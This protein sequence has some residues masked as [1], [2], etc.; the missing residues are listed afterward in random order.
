[1]LGMDPRETLVA[2]LSSVESMVTGRRTTTAGVEQSPQ[3]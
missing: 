3:E 2:T 1:M